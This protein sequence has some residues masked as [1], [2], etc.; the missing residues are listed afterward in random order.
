M[1]K[2]GPDFTRYG[3]SHSNRFSDITIFRLRPVFAIDAGTVTVPRSKLM[4]SSVA[5]CLT[6]TGGLI[7]MMVWAAASA[8]GSQQTE[9]A[10][11]STTVSVGSGFGDAGQ[12][13]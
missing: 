10:A 8:A 5:N 6:M 7:R 1:S 11:S 13:S 4:P 3:A 12:V 2:I 9:A